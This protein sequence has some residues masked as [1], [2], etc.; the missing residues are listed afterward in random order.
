MYIYDTQ[1]SIIRLFLIFMYFQSTR[2]SLDIKNA[3]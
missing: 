2:I 3:K 1:D